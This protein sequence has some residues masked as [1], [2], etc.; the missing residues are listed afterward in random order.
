M[1][2]YL[3]VL[4][5]YTDF[6]GRARRK[7]YWMFVL[8]NFIFA[9]VAML[10]DNLLGI[11]YGGMPYGYGPIYTIYGLAVFL[12]SLAVLIRRLHD[13]GK[14]GWWVFISLIPLAGGIWLLVLLATDSQPGENEFGPNPKDISDFAPDTLDGHLTN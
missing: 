10:L 12:P 7:E 1:N 14:N 4:R 2:W 13:I 8:F 9:I 3:K 5:Q 11:T 6:N